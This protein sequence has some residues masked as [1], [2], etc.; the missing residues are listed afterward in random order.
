MKHRELF[1]KKEL[2]SKKITIH[3]DKLQVRESM[4]YT[5][6]ANKKNAE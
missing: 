4:A 5:T 2:E 6:V 3:K 1:L